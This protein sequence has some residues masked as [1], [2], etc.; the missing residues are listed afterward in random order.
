MGYD[1]TQESMTPAQQYY[2]AVVIGYLVG[3]VEYLL[4][5]EERRSGILLSPV[6][7]GIDA[8]GAAI[9]GFNASVGGRSTN[10]LINKMGYSR[11]EASYLYYSLRCGLVHQGTAKHGLKFFATYEDFERPHPIYRHGD[12]LCLDSVKLAKDFVNAAKA[13][14][15]STREEI[16]HLP[17]AA[18]SGFH[19]LAS[20]NN[21]EDISSYANI[22]QRFLDDEYGSNS[23]FD[24]G[25]DLNA[26]LIIQRQ[27]G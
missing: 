7:N 9:E 13:L 21:I 27:E 18:D 2:K 16:Q 26:D 4:D 6:V 15:E 14:W 11:E 8:M 23:G 25:C 20:S 3:D 22:Y 10:A 12:W 17:V 24:P 1:A 5:R 19:A